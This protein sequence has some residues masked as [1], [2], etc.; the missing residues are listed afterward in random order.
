[1]KKQL[2]LLFALAL[3][4]YS[5]EP[6]WDK[7]DK[8]ISLIPKVKEWIV[9]DSDY[10]S[11]DMIGS[12]STQIHFEEYNSN[13]GS[14]GEATSDGFLSGYYIVTYERFSQ[15]YLVNDS[16]GLFQINMEPSPHTDS[17]NFIDLLL[18]GTEWQ[19][20]MTYEKMYFVSLHRH[21]EYNHKWQKDGIRSTCTLLD[22]LEVNGV[23]CDSVLFFQL[24]DFKSSLSVE[25]V[26]ELYY[27]KHIGLVQFS[28]N[29]SLSYKRNW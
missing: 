20:D 23:T 28:R 10:L 2:I 11:F 12:D 7:P 9:D 17:G 6:N 25:T 8:S 21:H 15:Y 16:T 19:Y 27:A 24:N 1:M 26:T 13:Y 5:C 3:I 14:G 4:L 18:F 29:D 22:S